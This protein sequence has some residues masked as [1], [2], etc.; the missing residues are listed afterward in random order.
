[1]IQP[2]PPCAGARRVRLDGREFW[3]TGGI[4]IR[5]I[6][7]MCVFTNARWIGKPFVL[8]PWQKRTLW[9]LFEIDEATRLRRYRRALIGVPRKNGKTEWAAALSLYLM[10]ADGEPASANY[11]AAGN[12]DQADLVFEAAKRMCSLDGAPL[13]DLVL[14][15]S[16]R[17]TSKSDPYS[18]FERLSSKGATKHGLNPHGVVFDELH[19]WGVGQHD[20]LWD[21]LTTGSGA[22]E[23]PLQVAITTAGSDLETSRCGGLY[24]HGRA[25]E[26]GEEVDDNFYFE[27]WEAPDECD[28]RDPEM[29]RISNPSYGVTVNEAFLR[30][31]LAGTN[32]ENG[33]RA[34]AISEA[35][36]RRLYLNQ[37]IEYG[38]APW[39]TR[40]QIQACRV[41]SVT[42]DP[43]LPAWVGVD[44]SRSTDATAVAWGQWRDGERPCKHTGEPC[45]YVTARTWERPRTPDGKWLEGWRVPVDEVREFIRGLN[46]ENSV[47]TNVFDPYGGRLMMLDLE[48]EGIV[49]EEMHQQ[50]KRR[51]SAASGMY[52]LI[53]QQRFH[54][55]DDV[56]ER[57]IMNAS[58]K[59][60]GEEGYYL[61]KRKAGKVMDAAQACSQVVYGTIWAPESTIPEVGFFSFDGG[62]E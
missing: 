26:R 3:S 13:A 19:V 23:Q 25:I 8:L 18:F 28:Y 24:L 53:A 43:A 38:E 40:E 32:I 9:R 34:G 22:R 1:M 44:L 10:L 59:A 39:V 48:A 11:C 37:W 31:E 5:F 52:D 6:E 7:T 29:W 51:S 49:C 12:E 16:R 15:E 54:Y 50:G 42:I 20:E 33:K 30:G 36:F 35:T 46:R 58:V 21:A 14:V 61:Q 17:L 2:T 56:I 62:D 47:V 41:P 27:W 57:H 45:L 4:P 60:V 55:A